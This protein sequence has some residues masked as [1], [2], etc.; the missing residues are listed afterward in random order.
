M[1]FPTCPTWCVSKH[2][3]AGLDLYHYAEVG[4]LDSGELTLVVSVTAW[5]TPDKPDPEPAVTLMWHPSDPD[6]NDVCLQDGIEFDLAESE[7]L[8]PLLQ[9]ANETLRAG[10]RA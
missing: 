10:R 3:G 2:S 6:D 7:A 9:K 4:R 8:I 5:A 1:S